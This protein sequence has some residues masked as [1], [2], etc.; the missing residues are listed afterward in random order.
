MYE[1]NAI[2]PQYQILLKYCCNTFM[3]F[4]PAFI[5]SETY[6]RPMASGN[7]QY[8]WKNMKRIL[9]TTHCTQTNNLLQFFLHWVVKHRAVAGVGGKG[10][11]KPTKNMKDEINSYLKIMHLF[12]YKHFCKDKY[13]TSRRTRKCA[14]RSTTG[15]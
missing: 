4:E 15:T 11:R 8:A 10:E 14:A 7:I 3:R 1:L 9:T 12:I 6:E 5:N 2:V 13:F